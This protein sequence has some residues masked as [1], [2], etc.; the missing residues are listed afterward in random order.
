[1]SEQL[2]NGHWGGEIYYTYA[3]VCQ[4]YKI[5]RGTLNRWF[6]K[7]LK[8]THIGAT[9]RIAASDLKAFIARS[10]PQDPLQ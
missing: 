1:M 8:R 5:S 4:M 9:R 10:R 6:E 3:E 2:S 7:G